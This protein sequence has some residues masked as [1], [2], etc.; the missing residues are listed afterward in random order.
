MLILGI[1]IYRIELAGKKS[2]TWFFEVFGKNPLF[3]YLLSEI[4]VILLYTFTNS[5][6]QTIY[7]SVNLGLYQKIAPG[8]IGSLLFAL[9]VMFFCW[10]VGW[11]MDR[12]KK[13]VRV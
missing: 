2:G 11:W 1:L 6:G 12:N 3:I 4:I 13:Y 9:S 7:E 10:L 5:K 8:P